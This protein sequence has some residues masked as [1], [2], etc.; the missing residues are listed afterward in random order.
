MEISPTGVHEAR[1]PRELLSKLDII[2]SAV[3]EMVV[4]AVQKSHAFISLSSLKTDAMANSTALTDR[5][6]AEVTVLCLREVIRGRHLPSH[7]AASAPQLQCDS[8]HF[9]TIPT[10][11]MF[12]TIQTL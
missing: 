1:L 12:T 6:K 10:H 4:M 7:R 9:I 3:L 8:F 5:P 11:F 2:G